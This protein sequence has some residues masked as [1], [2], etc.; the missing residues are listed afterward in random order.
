MVPDGQNGC[1]DFLRLAIRNCRNFLNRKTFNA[2]QQE[3]LEKVSKAE[4]DK[5]GSLSLIAG[6][7]GEI[8]KLQNQYTSYV[9]R[10][11]MYYVLASQRLGPAGTT[12]KVFK[13]VA[14]KREH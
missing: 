5:F 9:I 13:M 6:S 14:E 2:I 10:N 3:Y 12:G 4:S 11:G 7:E 8:A 1:F